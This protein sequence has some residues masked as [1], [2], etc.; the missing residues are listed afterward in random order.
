[1]TKGEERYWRLALSDYLGL[2]NQTER[3]FNDIASLIAERDEERALR[4]TLAD[5]CHRTA[6]ALRGVPP[7][8]IM[9]SFADLPE[10]VRALKAQL[11]RPLDFEPER[12]EVV[13]TEVLAREIAQ[14]KAQPWRRGE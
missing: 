3:L 4:E 11:N 6:M 8:D 1:M 7:P 13:G 9:W 14:L 10:R 5:I 2:K 12:G